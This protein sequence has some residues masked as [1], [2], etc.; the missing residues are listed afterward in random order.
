[1]PRKSFAATPKTTAT[2]TIRC[3]RRHPGPPSRI[4]TQSHQLLRAR[5]LPAHP[6]GS[7]KL[8]SPSQDRARR[9]CSTASSCSRSTKTGS[10]TARPQPSHKAPIIC[11]QRS[12]PSKRNPRISSPPSSSP[13]PPRS[14]HRRSAPPR[15]ILILTTLEHVQG[16][17]YV[18]TRSAKTAMDAQADS[19]SPTTSHLHRLHQQLRRPLLPQRHRLPHP[20]SSLLLGDAADGL[21]SNSQSAQ[22]AQFDASSDSRRAARG[23]LQR[24]HQSPL[25]RRPPQRHASYDGSNPTLLNAYGGFQVSETPPLLR[26]HRQALARARRRLRARQHPRRR[27]VRPRMARGRPQDPPP[28]HLRRLRRRRQGPDRPQDHLT[29]PPRH[30]RRLQRRPAHGRRV[31][32][33]PRAVERRRHPGAAARHARASSRSPPAPPGSANTAPSPIPDE[34]AFLASISPY[35]QLKPDVHYPEPLIFTTTKDDRVGPSPRPQ[36]R[37]PA[38]RSSTSPSSTTKSSKAATAPA[39]TSSRPRAPLPRNTPTCPCSS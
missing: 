9:L 1:M 34:R 8:A 28:A 16:R 10:P 23:H 17:A 11:S 25:L 32:P 37:R 19:P 18:Y 3:P 14:S 5:I 31:H 12:K 29:P 26:H 39:P 36:V 33:A 4:I 35:N 30:R 13:P 7:Q 2:A 6:Q 21:A 27:R 38:W 15:T 24:R 20:S 22:P